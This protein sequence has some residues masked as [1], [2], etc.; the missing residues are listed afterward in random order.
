MLFMVIWGSVFWGSGSC[1]EVFSLW[2]VSPVVWSRQGFFG[3]GTLYVHI[4]EQ[5]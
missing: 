5:P 2:G 4:E 1:V 3:V